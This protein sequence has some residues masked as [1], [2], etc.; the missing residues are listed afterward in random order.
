M[1]AAGAIL[2][3]GVMLLVMVVTNIDMF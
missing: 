1:V 3:L 2:L